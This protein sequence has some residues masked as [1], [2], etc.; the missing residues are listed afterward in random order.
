MRAAVLCPGPSLSTTWFGR[1]GFVV[2]VEHDHLVE[3]IREHPGREQATHAGENEWRTAPLWGLADGERAGALLDDA[4]ARTITEAILWHG[5]EA[6]SARDRFANATAHERAR[7]LALPVRI[8]GRVGG[9][10]LTLKGEGALPLAQL[11]KAHEAWLPGFMAGEI[12]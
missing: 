7:L 6:A 4:R 11:R 1:D 10:G 5:G 2:T 3:V 12:G 9:E 8:V